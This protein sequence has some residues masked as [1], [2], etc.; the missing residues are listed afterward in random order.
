MLMYPFRTQGRAVATKLIH[1]PSRPSL[2]RG[3]TTVPVW[4][5]LRLAAL[6][7]AGAKQPGLPRRPELKNKRD[8]PVEAEEGRLELDTYDVA[9]QADV[10]TNIPAVH[11]LTA[12]GVPP[13]WQTLHTLRQH[14]LSGSWRMAQPKRL[15]LWLLRLPAKLTTHGR[16]HYLQLLHGEPIRL[17]AALRGL[18]HDIPCPAPA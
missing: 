1:G 5:P 3:P 7:S 16:K 15:R 11:A 13:S 4:H 14:L 2:K 9:R 17:L 18:N 6:A 10:L 8:K 12:C